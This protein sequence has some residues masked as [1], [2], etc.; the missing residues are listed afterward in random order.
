MKTVNFK[1]NIDDQVLTPFGDEGFIEMLGYREGGPCY[2]VQSQIKGEWFKERQ[3]DW[4]YGQD[5]QETISNP[6][7]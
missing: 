7:S 3:L 1:F 2:Y 4:Y 6:K 5:P